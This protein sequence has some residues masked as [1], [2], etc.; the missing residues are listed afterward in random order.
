M[1]DLTDKQKERRGERQRGWHATLDKIT[2]KLCEKFKSAHSA[3][4]AA[5]GFALLA[6]RPAKNCCTILER[7]KTVREHVC[8]DVL[9]KTR[10]LM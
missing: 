10:A 8:F 6:K 3:A 2:R 1:L 9:F 5:P 4:G 7:A